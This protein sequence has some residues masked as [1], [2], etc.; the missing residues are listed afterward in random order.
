[1]NL[2]QNGLLFL[3]KLKNNGKNINI[4]LPKNLPG[5]KLRFLAFRLFLSKKELASTPFRIPFSLYGEPVILDSNSNIPFLFSL[6]PFNGL[7]LL[8]Y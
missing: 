4:E 1:M 5:K 8:D 7:N 2:F 6:L 3:P